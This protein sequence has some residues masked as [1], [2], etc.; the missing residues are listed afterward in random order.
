MASC[1]DLRD[2]Y[3]AFGVDDIVQYA[4]LSGKKPKPCVIKPFFGK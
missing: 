1:G 3:I 4:L 2:M